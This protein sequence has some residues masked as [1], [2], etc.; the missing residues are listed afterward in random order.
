M[1]RQERPDQGTYR[2]THQTL[3]RGSTEHRN[4]NLRARNTKQKSNLNISKTLGH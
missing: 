3:N 1:T 4:Q 2:D